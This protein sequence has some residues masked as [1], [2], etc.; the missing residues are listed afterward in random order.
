MEFETHPV[1][2]QG[3]TGFMIAAPLFKPYE[4]ASKSSDRDLVARTALIIGSAAA[5]DFVAPI[6]I[7]GAASRAVVATWTAY[8]RPLAQS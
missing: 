4:T 8:K 5:I 6:L 3:N 2:S 1:F 7:A